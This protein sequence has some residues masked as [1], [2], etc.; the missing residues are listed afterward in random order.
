MMHKKDCFF[1]GTIFKLHG[2]KGEINI[3]YEDN[4]IIEPSLIK[5][6]LLEINYELVPFFIE[7]IRIKKPKILLAK[8]EDLNTEEEAKKLINKKIYLPNKIFHKLKK[9]DI[10]SQDLVGYKVLDLNHGELGK[11]SYINS[12]TVQRLLYV[13]KDGKEFCF[14]IHDEFIKKIL[15]NKR[16]IEVKIPK[17]LI[18]LN[19]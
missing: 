19:E 5:Y 18:Y 9:K 4:I 13:E 12:K 3:Y 10:T 11:V 14:P 7:T 2:Y 15:N 8:F 6:L 1:F 17:D 16:I